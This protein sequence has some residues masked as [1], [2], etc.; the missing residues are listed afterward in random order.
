MLNGDRI[1]LDK[2]ISN[3]MVA[4]NGVPREWKVIKISFGLLQFIGVR[5]AVAGHVATNEQEI[6]FLLEDL[7]A[8]GLPVGVPCWL[9]SVRPRRSDVHIRDMQKGPCINIGLH[10]SGFSAH[11]E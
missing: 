9:E 7:N 2:F 10:L 4:G 3:L 6:G 8:G 5:C 11:Q 1:A